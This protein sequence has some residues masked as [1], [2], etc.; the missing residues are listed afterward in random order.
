MDMMNLFNTDDG[1]YRDFYYELERFLTSDLN[2]F[3]LTGPRKVGKSFALRQ[4]KNKYSHNT[5]LIDFKQLDNQAQETAKERVIKTIMQEPDCIILIDEITYLEGADLFL[6]SLDT[7]IDDVNSKCKIII[8]GSQQIAIRQ[9][10]LRA[11]SNKAKFL[12]VRFLD[13]HEWL[14]YVKSDRITEDTFKDFVLN[15][16]NFS[17]FS[18]IRDYLESLLDETIIS[19]FKSNNVIFRNDV[20]GVTVEDLLN[21]MYCTLISLHNQL[22]CNSFYKKDRYLQDVKSYYVQQM[23]TTEDLNKCVE[24]SIMKNYRKA[25]NMDNEKFKRVIG[26]LLENRL[27]TLTYVSKGIDDTLNLDDW[28][29]GRSDSIKTKSEF[30]NKVKICSRY[31]MFYVAILRDTL[32][33]RFPENELPPR[34][35]GGIV[36]CY[37]RGI[38][39]VK[40]TMEFHDIE[41]NEIDYVDYDSQEAI[42]ITISN[43]KLSKVNL[44]LL[45]DN[46]KKILLTKNKDYSKEGLITIP[47]YEYIYKLLNE[48]NSF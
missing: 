35:L 17:K 9:W 23:F 48:Q 38:L 25:L 8:T 30:F 20:S 12:N 13:Y 43:K 46:Y 34:I 29:Y 28:L 32:K 16:H 10:A 45:G 7:L 33:G 41:D 44:D 40:Y 31:P 22:N 11:F 2:V 21:V 36:E 15:V 42:E 39:S 19:N 27:I 5:F 26:F 1:F 3:I 47:Y 37:V 18:S 4:L 6:A 24:D 14:R